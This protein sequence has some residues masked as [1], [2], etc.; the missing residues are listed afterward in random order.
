MAMANMGQTVADDRT[1]RW[2][3]PAAWTHWELIHWQPGRVRVRWWPARSSALAVERLE[4]ALAARSDV[5]AVRVVRAAASVTIVYHDRQLP[6]AGLRLRLDDWL[7]LAWPDRA[8]LLQPAP[9]PP[10]PA[11][12]GDP[13]EAAEDEEEEEASLSQTLTALAL[14]G[15][16]RWRPL[17]PLRVLATVALLRAV[18]PVAQRAWQS[19]TVDRRLN[20]DCMD[21]LAIGLSSSGGSLV[22]P[23][24]VL[25]LHALGDA[26]R[27]RTARATA[28]RTANLSDAIGRFAW[29]K[30]NDG[31]PQ[32]I[33]SDQLQVGDLVVVYPGEQIPA[34]GPVLSGEA[35]IDEKSLTGEPL[36]VAASAGRWVHASTLV[37][38]GQ[39]Y[40]RAERVG[41]QTRAAAS[42]ALLEQAPVYDT[43]MANYAERLADRAIGPAL[44][45]A[46]VVLIATRDPARAA[47]IL[48]L[49]FVTGIRLSI[50]TAFLGALNH[51]TRHGVLVRSGRTLEQ[52]A[53]IDTVVFDK[54]GTLTQGD[55]VLEQV[56]PA[57][58]DITPDQLLQLAASAE[59]R[60]THPV[61]EAIVRA[62]AD[63]GLTLSDRGEWNYEVGLG[64]RAQLAAGDVLVG[65]ARFLI[66]QGVTGLGEWLTTLDQQA[67]SQ[68]SIAQPSIYVAVDGRFMGEL[69]YTDPLRPESAALV[70]TLQTELGLDV[71]LLT[72]D[73]PARAAQVARALEIPTDRVY[74]EAFPDRKATIIRDLRRSG[75][76][77]AFVGDGL[78]DSVALAYADVSISFEQGSEI[79][80]ETAD[81]VLMN[82]HLLDLLEVLTIARQTQGLIEQNTALVVL[83]NL[84]ALGLA[85]TRGLSP[86]IATAIHNGSA[87]AAGLNSLRPLIQHHFFERPRDR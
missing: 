40:L 13:I 58:P 11:T 32:R 85:T 71:R 39:I 44:I 31:P 51:T 36:P 82:N 34:D 29:V 50:P 65:S 74:A 42:L 57:Q 48:T 4:T 83:P 23:S 41:N 15:L 61:A 33:P 55:I 66:Q 21:L 68:P 59:Q 45:L 37:R 12:V 38:S 46:L 35:T 18:W 79:A 10:A 9:E 22:V 25:T 27:D 6:M 7:A 1:W 81:V 54:T 49:D 26:I 78:N 67:S 70:Q 17:L 60:L 30:M 86:P 80:R 28:L 20:I 87:I 53:A 56:L 72:G 75:R 3:R 69:R 64:V 52:L 24:L 47:A 16:A 63:R 14:A 43:R 62:A 5:A 73:T 77:V 19:V 8:L 76:T 2:E 84:I